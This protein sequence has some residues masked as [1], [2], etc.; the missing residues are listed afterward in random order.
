MSGMK[1][2]GRPVR[3]AIAGIFFGL[4]VGLDL[5]VLGLVPLDSPFLSIL[6]VLGLLGGLALG[7]TAPFGGRPSEDP[8]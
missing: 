5:F 1:R 2:R 6:V 3:G 8:A 4:F 7:L